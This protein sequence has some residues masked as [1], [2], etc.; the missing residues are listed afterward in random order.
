VR[1]GSVD[2]HAIGLELVQRRPRLHQ[3]RHQYRRLRTSM[4][5]AEAMNL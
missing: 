5:K 1:A 2:V 3:E 4:L